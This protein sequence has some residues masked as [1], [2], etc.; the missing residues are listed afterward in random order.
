V[1]GDDPVSSLVAQI[2]K[3]CLGLVDEGALSVC[4]RSR[5]FDGGEHGVDVRPHLWARVPLLDGVPIVYDGLVISD[6]LPC[7]AWP[8]CPDRTPDSLVKRRGPEGLDL[9]GVLRLS[10]VLPKDNDGEAGDD[11]E[12]DALK[13]SVI[14]HDQSLPKPTRR[15]DHI[16]LSSISPFSRDQRTH[17]GHPGDRSGA[18]RHPGAYKEARGRGLRASLHHFESEVGGARC[19]DRVCPPQ[20]DPIGA[21]ILE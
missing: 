3:A 6:D 21:E 20:F 10:E 19:L 5:I 4:G 2:E 12:Q 14:H 1:R 9:G 11:I 15:F 18:G 8:A 17:Q 16:I 13:T 7:A